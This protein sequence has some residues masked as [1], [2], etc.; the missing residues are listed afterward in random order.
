MALSVLPPIPILCFYLEMN[1]LANPINVPWFYDNF[2]LIA[3]P[4]LYFAVKVEAAVQSQFSQ[5]QYL[6]KFYQLK[7]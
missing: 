2:P 5:N 7:W 4:S 6:S 3:C 1:L